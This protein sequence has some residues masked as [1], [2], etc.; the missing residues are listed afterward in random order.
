V[1]DLPPLDVRA[2]G[3]G[4]PLLLVHGGVNRDQTWGPQAVLADHWRLIVPARRGYPPSPPTERQDWETDA[5]DVAD[6]LATE[7]AHCA[8]FSYGGVGLA[9]A[10]AADPSR[11]LSLT[12]IEPPL[13]AVATDRP[14][15]RDFMA[16][17][18]AYTGDD[19][20]AR[21]Q[22]REE[23]EAVARIRFPDSPEQERAFVEARRLA[24]GL[25]P[26]GEAQPDLTAVAA[27][28]VPS[29][30]VSGD[31]HPAIEAVCDALADQLGAERLKL[32]GR[33]HAVQHVPGF[34]E[35]FERFL[36]GNAA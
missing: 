13:F 11:L 35:H 14:E 34:N 17:A 24:P 25:R 7:P 36:R 4:E 18:A 30:V 15:V 1:T 10:A 26:P 32:A 5:H 21:E 8:G 6:L 16:L 20:V 27:A 29:L 19:P 22:A 12:L 33:G 28:G 23:F 31:H 2:S 3:A 9:V